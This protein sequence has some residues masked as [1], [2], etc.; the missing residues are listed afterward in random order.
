V[1]KLVD[2]LD[3]KS[4]GGNTV[5]VRFRPS[6]PMNNKGLAATTAKPFYLYSS[7]QIAFIL[8]PINNCLLQCSVGWADCYTLQIGYRPA[9]I[10]NPC[11][12]DN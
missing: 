7:P 5:S 11:K 2:A 12:T 6:V 3:S 10:Y 4:S 9:K 1:A 8:L